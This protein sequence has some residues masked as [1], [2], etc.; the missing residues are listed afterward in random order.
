[1]TRMMRQYPTR[2][3]GLLKRTWWQRM[4]VIQELALARE[5]VFHCGTKKASIEPLVAALTVFRLY[6]MAKIGLLHHG[7]HNYVPP[8][9]DLRPFM[10]LSMRRSE[11]LDFSALKM[12]L[13]M[14]LQNFCPYSRAGRRMNAT[15][16]RDYVF[17]L[18]GLSNSQQ[19]GLLADYGDSGIK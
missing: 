16:P 3:H 19:L 4:W 8:Y 18:L 7:P 15:D 11:A 12:P 1:V 17:A 13:F 10:I 5:T 9:I 6:H 2:P 14:H